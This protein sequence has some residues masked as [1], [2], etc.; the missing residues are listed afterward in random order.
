MSL[1]LQELAARFRERSVLDVQI[2][3]GHLAAGTLAAPEVEAAVHRL[4]GA[5][6]IFGYKDIGALAQEIDISF[7]TGQPVDPEMVEALLAELSTAHSAET[8]ICPP[9]TPLGDRMPGAGCRSTVLIVEDDELLGAHAERELRRLGYETILADSAA[10]LLP[11]IDQLPHIDLLFTDLVM[12]G[13]VDGRTLAAEM[14]R[15]RPDLRVLFTSGRAQSGV[16][17]SARPFLPKP[18]RRGALAAAVKT[19]LDAPASV[20]ENLLSDERT[21]GNTDLQGGV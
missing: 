6:G 17:D 8:L 19:V 20:R 13:S 1:N 18:Y 3:Q 5:A 16:E 4:A 11:K 14:Q 21:V 10:D 9:K 12:P 15:R 7:A 2:L